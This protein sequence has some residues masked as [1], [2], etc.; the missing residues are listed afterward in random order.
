M[1]ALQMCSTDNLDVVDFGISVINPISDVEETED[2]EYIEEE[3]LSDWNHPSEMWE[4]FAE[5]MGD[6]DDD[7]DDYQ[8]EEEIDEDTDEDD[9]DDDGF[10]SESSVS[11][12][13]LDIIKKSINGEKS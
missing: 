9:L 13:E 12:N 11:E 4:E 7:E 10:D 5:M 2:E 3:S 8:E 6:E 1:P